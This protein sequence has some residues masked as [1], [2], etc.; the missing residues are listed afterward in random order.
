[1][2]A[3]YGAWLTGSCFCVRPVC[4]SPMSAMTSG[5]CHLPSAIFHPPSSAPIPWLAAP[6]PREGASGAP[7]PAARRSTGA[8]RSSTPQPLRA[9]LKAPL[10]ACFRQCFDNLLSVHVRLDDWAGLVAA[11]ASDGNC[12]YQPT[13]TQPPTLPGRGATPEIRKS[14]EGHNSRPDPFS[15]F[16]LTPKN[17]CGK[18]K[19]KRWDLHV[20]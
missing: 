11:R 9:N 20:P 12:G 1:M 7:H 8:S 18:V 6:Y 10:G 16:L 14:P 19:V 3:T 15:L 2:P 17:R 4:D 13:E 5:L